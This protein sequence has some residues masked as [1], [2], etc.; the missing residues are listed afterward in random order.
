MQGCPDC[1]GFV[2]ALSHGDII[3]SESPQ[4]DPEEEAKLRSEG[5]N[6]LQKWNEAMNSFGDAFRIER[7][8]EDRFADCC[9]SCGSRL[10]NGKCPRCG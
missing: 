10:I 8:P 7:F 4:T 9:P 3:D 1:N 6:S 5:Y 2:V